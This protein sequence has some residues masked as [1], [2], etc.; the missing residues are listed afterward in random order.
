MHFC[1]SG[2]APCDS[3]TIFFVLCMVCGFPE[4]PGKADEKRQ[5]ETQ[6]KED[7]GD[8]VIAGQRVD[9]PQKKHGTYERAQREKFFC[10]PFWKDSFFIIMLDKDRTDR[11]T[12]GKSEKQH[13]DAQRRLPVRRQSPAGYVVKELWDII[14]DPELGQ[15]NE[16]EKNRQYR[17]GPGR[18]PGFGIGKNHGRM[19]QKKKESQKARSLAD[20]KKK[21]MFHGVF[22]WQLCVCICF[23][24]EEYE[25]FAL[26]E[27]L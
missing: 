6:D 26:T 18:Q 24:T 17:A 5:I 4:D 12:G 15:D 1:E 13:G 8:T 7:P 11:E 25:N 23:L 19:C 16:R 20:S 3:V 27:M 2:F 10:R 9:V 22:L 14:I 21:G